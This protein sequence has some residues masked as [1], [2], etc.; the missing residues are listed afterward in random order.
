[1][2]E[3]GIRTL[4]NRCEK[5]LCAVFQSDGN[6]LEVAK[7]CGWSDLITSSAGLKRVLWFSCLTAKFKLFW[8]PT[9]LRR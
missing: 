8:Q 6:W 5:Y 9:Q 3:H 2:F 7:I 4:R 1:M